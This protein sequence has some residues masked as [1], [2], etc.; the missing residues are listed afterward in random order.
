MTSPKRPGWFIILVSVLILWGLAGC[1]SFYG[2]ML[3]RPPM[4][5][6][7]DRA[8][9][10]GLPGWFFWDYAV[11]VIAGLLGSVALLAR[12]GIAWPLS[13]LSLVAVVV[14]FGY[15]FLATGLL[16]HKGAVATIPFPAFIIGMA[17]VQL[18]LASHARNRGWVR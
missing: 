18:W 10:A 14:Q 3:M 1:A 12:R 9:V 5:D 16:A 17:V 11:A 8:F 7:W 4:G 6:D 2:Q 15:V 13:L